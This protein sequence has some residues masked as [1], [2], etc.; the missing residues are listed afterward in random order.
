MNIT[1][2][3]LQIDFLISSKRQSNVRIMRII[4][5]RCLNKNFSKPKNRNDYK[6]YNHAYFLH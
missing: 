3:Y 6:L 4:D 2:K 1:I 5:Q